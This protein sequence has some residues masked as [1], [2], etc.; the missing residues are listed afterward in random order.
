MSN[1]VMW[2][3]VL[4]TALSLGL[5]LVLVSCGGSSSTQSGTLRLQI[6]NLPSR[7]QAKVR[8]TGPGYS[9]NFSG[10]D[11]VTVPVGSYSISAEGIDTV[12]EAWSAAVFE[13]PVQV[14]EGNTANAR[15]DYRATTGNLELSVLGLPAGATAK[16]TLTGPGGF[17]NLVDASKSFKKLKT[18]DYT[19][20]GQ[21]VIFG[22][23]TYLPE[24][25]K[26]FALVGGKTN[27]ASLQYGLSFG[28]ISISFL[29]SF[30]LGTKAAVK[31][32]GPN[33]YE[34]TIDTNGVL[35]D[36]KAGMYTITS[37]NVAANGF[38][39]E[40]KQASRIVEVMS[41]KTSAVQ[42]DYTAI[43]GKIAATLR[44]LPMG[45]MGVAQGNVRITGP[46]GFDQVLKSTSILNDLKLGNYAVVLSDLQLGNDFYRPTT[47][48]P[49]LV[50]EAGK[51]STVSV[52][53]SLMRPDI[54]NPSQTSVSIVAD[55]NKDTAEAEVTIS[56]NG[57]ASLNYTT[58]LP[59]TNPFTV[60][61]LS[62]G[63]GTLTE[64][65][66]ATIRFKSTCPAAFGEY[67][68][69]LLIKSNDP[70]S[71]QKSVTINL[72]C[73]DPSNPFDL[74]V[75]GFY[76]SQSVQSLKANSAGTVSLISN[77]TGYARAFVLANRNRKDINTEVMLELR[78]AGG[79]PG[80]S[81]MLKLEGS[82]D[83]ITSL[84]E[85]NLATTYNAVVPPELIQVGMEAVLR[86]TPVSGE[87]KLDNNTIELTG[88]KKP[89]VKGIQPFR[90]TVVPSRHRGV[91]PGLSSEALLAEVKQMMPVADAID[92]Q[93]HAPITI[94]GELSSGNV[95]EQWIE[96]VVA[97]RMAEGSKRYYYGLANA[98][99]DA[100]YGGL[101]YVPA[102]PGGNWPVSVGGDWP[103]DGP[104]IAA[105][106]IGH[107]WGRYHAP[108]AVSANN[109]LDPNWPKDSKYAEAAI[110]VWG[111]DVF[112]K[113][114]KDTNKKDV[115]SYCDNTWVSDYN[116]NAILEFRAA[117]PTIPANPAPNPEAMVLLATGRINAQ[118]QAT[119]NPVVVLDTTPTPTL[120][121]PYTLEVR[122]DQGKIIASQP[123]APADLGHGIEQRHFA[124]TVVVPKA[125]KL[126]GVR[127]LGLS[128]QA[129]AVRSPA[130]Q[131][132]RQ[133]KAT[134]VRQIDTNRWDIEW[135]GGF[136]RRAI[137]RDQQTREVLGIADGQSLSIEP[138]K[139]SNVLEVFLSDGLNTT[140]QL[141]S[142]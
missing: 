85:G 70:D 87:T 138:Q 96:Q 132:Q 12:D 36:L 24:P 34:K 78:M 54:S 63:A 60:A 140:K 45:V 120:P 127:V 93:T 64:K 92:I 128:D 103:D 114:I 28:Q 18:G 112:A 15:V 66:S 13:T 61:V 6:N 79:M 7:L 131:P 43:T 5:V 67:T 50:V 74:S 113:T 59:T 88:S 33:N 99:F 69:R 134:G 108:C 44:G 129:L 19:I 106:E 52:Q 47:T 95:W 116:Y 53:Y 133:A 65:Q 122:D 30:P 82:K 20:G 58:E 84:N 9:K 29:P 27:T 137:V 130:V 123:F 68:G 38:T 39:Y 10:S 49:M 17:S 8:I 62:G 142:R 97:L 139:L 111:I 126:G 22:G 41:G 86:V 48:K 31:V 26:T 37:V 80:A 51:E 109:G 77:R 75:S 73:D 90:I 101:G 107:N 11:V 83:A 118:E 121:G 72:G 141:V 4:S 100:A 25:N 76:I 14:S 56:N 71:P 42:L 117:E 115:M 23:D 125:V 40:P 105:H 135:D 2:R 35:T 102:T 46:N 124:L 57:V 55:V 98:G 16:A 94:S 104:N 119:L 136:Y 1:N 110:G 21:T 91:L 32:T 89:V 81:A 3:R